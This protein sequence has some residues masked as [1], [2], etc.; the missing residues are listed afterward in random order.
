MSNFRT[1]MINLYSCDLDTHLS[2]HQERSSDCEPAQRVSVWKPVACSDSFSKI[3]IT[4]RF[5][6]GL[7]MPSDSGA[8]TF[9]SFHCSRKSIL[10]IVEEIKAFVPLGMCLTFARLKLP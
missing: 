2:G 1:P 4:Q 9:N 3:G 10:P 6:I 8:P 7:R 5:R